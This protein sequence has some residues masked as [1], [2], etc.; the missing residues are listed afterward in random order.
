MVR[1]RAPYLHVIPGRVS[2][3][4]CKTCNFRPSRGLGLI[5]ETE[6][7]GPGA[8]GSSGKDVPSGNTKLSLVDSGVP[9]PCH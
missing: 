2:P 4:L 1:T 7:Q 3:L 5:M 6:S 9:S 8:L